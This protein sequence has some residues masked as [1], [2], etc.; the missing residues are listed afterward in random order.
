M[1]LLLHKSYPQVELANHGEIKC[2]LLLYLTN[3]L[4]LLHNIE[5]FKPLGGKLPRDTQR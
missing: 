3:T 4:I 1:L 2:V 5:D